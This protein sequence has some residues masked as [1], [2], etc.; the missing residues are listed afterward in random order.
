M[1]HPIITDP[2]SGLK[3]LHYLLPAMGQAQPQMNVVDTALTQI[4]ALLAQDLFSDLCLVSLFDHGIENVR[5]CARGLKA[6]CVAPAAM[7]AVVNVHPRFVSAEAMA[8]ARRPRKPFQAQLEVPFLADGKQIGMARLYSRTQGLFSLVSK[9]HLASLSKM[10]GAWIIQA[11]KHEL[12]Q[13]M[14]FIDPRT[15]LFSAAYYQAFLPTAIAQARR[16]KK[17]LS[18]VA[19]DSN[20]VKWA[21]ETHGYP[22]GTALIV[23]TAQEVKRHLR[24]SDI[25]A[26]WGGD[27][28]L[29]LLPDTELLAAMHLVEILRAAITQLTIVMPAG[30]TKTGVEARFSASLA[31]GAVAL[32]KDES[33]DG[34]TRRAL[35][36]VQND[37]QH[38]RDVQHQ[39]DWKQDTPT[40]S[41]CTSE[42]SSLPES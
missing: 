4:A 32:E 30:Y 19:Y 10:T 20:D 9:A 24:A 37:K 41:D 7:S 38:Q 15:Q 16:D 2:T 31:V 11:M 29:I 39:R 1:T 14:A 25:P 28:V 22:A 36:A 34:L 33:P 8:V 40:A 6:E 13:R 12:D 27:E 42:V 21:N 3:P 23:E 26:R 17:S 18:V 5:A 35:L